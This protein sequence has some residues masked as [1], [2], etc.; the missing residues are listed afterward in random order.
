MVKRIVALAILFIAT[1]FL[2][3]PVQAQQCAPYRVIYQFGCVPRQ[4]DVCTAYGGAYKETCP[5][6]P[7]WCDDNPGSSCIVTDNGGC[8][9]VQR[10]E[11]C[12]QATCTTEE[13]ANECAEGPNFNSNCTTYNPVYHQCYI[14][15]GGCNAPC[16]Y[17][18]QCDSGLT[19]TNGS[20]YGASCVGSTP[21]PSAPTGTPN[22][23]SGVNCNSWQCGSS[24]GNTNC[25]GW[26]PDAWCN[27]TQVCRDDRCGDPWNCGSTPPSTPPPTL[28]PTCTLTLPA[29]YTLDVNTG[30]VSATAATSN[31]QNGTIQNVQFNITSSI[32]SV[33]PSSASNSPYSTSITPIGAGTA[34]LTA[35]AYMGGSPRCSDTAT[36]TITDNQPPD[37]SNFTVPQ[38]ITTGESVMISTNITDAGSNILPYG[39]F[40]TSTTTGWPYPNDHYEW[41]TV[42]NNPVVLGA[43]GSYFAK[44]GRERLAG[45]PDN[46]PPYDPYVTTDWIETG[47]NLS[48]KSYTLEFL[49]KGHQSG[50]TQVPSILLQR[51]PLGND[52]TGTNAYIPWPNFDSTGFTRFVNS[53]TFTTPSNGSTTSRL[54]PVLRAPLSDWPVYYDSVKIYKTGGGSVTFASVKFYYL[55]ATQNPCTG[56]WT[57]IGGSVIRQ[58]SKYSLQWN[59]TGVP[60]GSYYVVVNANDSQG[61]AMTGNPGNCTTNPLPRINCGTTAAIQ[62]CAPSCGG[63]SCGNTGETPGAI[64]NVLVNGQVSGDLNLTSSQSLT[65]SWTDPVMTNG[66]TIDSYQIIRWKQNG[67]NTTPPSPCNA[68][69]NCVTDNIS[70]GDDTS[71]ATVQPNSIH[72]DQFRVAVRAL[73]STCAQTY[74]AW[75]T[76]RSYNLVYDITFRLYDDPNASGSPTCSGSTANPAAI[77]S[78]PVS[79]TG[80]NPT[81]V[82]NQNVLGNSYTLT[83]PFGPTS[84]WPRTQASGYEMTLGPIPYTDPSTA[85]FCICPP[86]GEQSTCLDQ[87][88]YT[89]AA[90][91]NRNLFVGNVDLSNDPWWQTQLGNIYAAN[92]YASNIPQSCADNPSECDANLITGGALGFSSDSAGVQPAG[93]PLSGGVAISANGWY[94]AY[95]GVEQPHAVNTSHDNMTKEDY[96]YFARQVDL[97]AAVQLDGTITELPSGAT[98]LADGTEVYYR[99]GDLIVDYTS[100]QTVPDTRKIVIFINGNV[101]LTSTPDTQMLEVTQGGYIGFISNGKITFEGSVGNELTYPSG[102]SST[103]NVAGVFV[104]DQIIVASDADASTK[105]NQFIGEG[106]YVGWSGVML[107]RTFDNTTN[108]IDRALNAT[109]PSERF[110]FRPDFTINTPKIMHQPS[111]IWQETN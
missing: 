51:E 60:T 31:V 12:N 109:N 64:T 22:P 52:W 63:T 5:A 80:A 32:A 108:A 68:A 26:T 84:A 36:V 93:A 59:T 50:T 7:T 86:S 42:S 94:T 28:P 9:V 58:G 20:C 46:D 92:S 4:I 91:A 76:A 29:S 21:P 6:Y 110:I 75:S 97:N 89:S 83:L 35:T 66:G 56:T 49:G 105:D 104:A 90:Y 3:T 67:A 62:A 77:L 99:N 73:N 111:I 15:Q 45:Q 57:Q 54:R 27:Q 74:G 43:E 16:T 98:P 37:C 72:G 47:E 79:V 19:C 65:V 55:N 101:S 40:E 53:L 10:N 106:T 103:P 2:I 102:G 14:I 100:T 96:A 48:G 87:S 34:T 69:S 11:P 24:P 78:T 30:A 61:A 85:Y 33:S 23:C 8:G 70:A 107:E 25:S 38:P 41:R 95:N 17:N 44:F 13:P 18:E 71:S 39:S 1:F 82:L 88:L 81:A